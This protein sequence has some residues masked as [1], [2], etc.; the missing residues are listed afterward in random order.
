VILQGQGYFGGETQDLNI[1]KKLSAESWEGTRG[2]EVRVVSAKSVVK[3]IVSGGR[4]EN[5]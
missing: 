5:V 1:A 4:G 2:V 3:I